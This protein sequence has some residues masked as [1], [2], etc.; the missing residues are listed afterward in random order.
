MN[1]KIIATIFL[2]TSV[3]VFAGHHGDGHKSMGNSEEWEIETYTS[4]AP[5]FIGNFATVVGASGEVI[6]EGTNGWTCLPFIP[7]PKMGFKTA[8]EAAPACADANAVAWANAYIAQA[9]PEIENDGWIWMKHGDTGV[10]N[11]RPYSEGDKANTK[12]EDWIYS[13]SHLMLMPKDPSSLDGVSTDFTTGA[14]YVMMKGTPFVHLM[15]PLDG[16]YDYQP[17]SAPK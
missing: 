16:Y 10:D 1:N 4:A 6:R 14:P 3:G 12:A 11:F 7:M 8:N 15:I 2:F 13:G 5:D 9:K 17:E